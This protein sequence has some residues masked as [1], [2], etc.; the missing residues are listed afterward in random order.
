MFSYRI[1]LLNEQV[2]ILKFVCVAENRFKALECLYQRAIDD[3]HVATAISEAD[4]MDI[5][6]EVND[7]VVR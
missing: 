3:I 2:C 1:Y 4:T 5:S 6:H 7:E